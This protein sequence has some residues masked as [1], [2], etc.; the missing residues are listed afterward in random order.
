[1]ALGTVPNDVHVYQHVQS[2]QVLQRQRDT[3]TAWVE[4]K[5]NQRYELNVGGPYTVDDAHQ[6]MV[7][8]IWIL[9]GQSNMRGYGFFDDNDNDN[10]KNSSSSNNNN[11]NNN[12][13]CHVFQSCESWGMVPANRPVHH[14]AT[15]PRS[16]HHTLPDPT[17]REPSIVFDRGASLAPAFVRKYERT[18]GVPVGVV[19]CAHGGVTIQQWMK[20]DDNDDNN[21]N[22]DGTLYGAMMDKI[23]LVGGH[24]TGVLWYQG[25]SDAVHFDTAALYLRDFTRWICQLHDDIS[26]KAFF[27][28]AQ[29]GRTISDGG[30][31]IDLAW[32]M[33]RKAQLDICLQEHHFGERRIAIVS[34]VDTDMDD[35]IHL[36]ASGLR[37]VGGR[38]ADAA[39]AL[40]A[41]AS[42]ESAMIYATDVTMIHLPYNHGK[43]WRHILRL[44]LNLQQNV[45]WRN[46]DMITGFTIHDMHPSRD[47]LLQVDVIHSARINDQQQVDL[48][49]TEKGYQQIVA[50]EVGQYVLRYGYGKNPQCNLVTTTN[51]AALAFGPLPILVTSLPD[52]GVRLD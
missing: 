31:K 15:S 5:D 2:Y 14:L 39:T 17:V 24:Y 41:N 47:R 11:N 26:Q 21:S 50:G 43:H 38:M 18:L 37:K 19:P 10:S 46:K 22:A 8:D 32:S 34:T 23:R 30:D 7:G 45:T 40:V 35:Y 29:I 52:S 1:M 33:V 12:K 44:D 25:E 36:S 20:H 27:V 28:Y 6:V 48:Y 42:R 16:V 3:D 9:A 4:G 49:L 13:G 51:V